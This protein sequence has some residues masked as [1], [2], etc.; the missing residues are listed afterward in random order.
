[1]KQFNELPK[2]VQNHIKNTLKAFPEE[3]VTYENGAYHYG[4]CLK[5][6]YA[7]DYKY[8][9]TYKDTDIY[10]EEERMINYIESFHDYPIEYKGKR[11][12]R[13]LKEVGYDWS[14]KFKFENGNL[15]RA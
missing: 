9:G 11:D 1:M 13:M 15:V 8:I 2:E 4:V 3:T 5:A 10:N 14:V 12:Y 6:N 7:A